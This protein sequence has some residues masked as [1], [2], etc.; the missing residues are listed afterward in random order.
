MAALICDLCGGKLTMGSG[1]IATCDSCGMEHTKDRMK[2]KVQE[3][4]GVV[5]VDE[6]HKVD[7]YLE[8]A[9]NAYDN[10]NQAEA[11]SYCNKIIENDPSNYKAWLIK[12][13]A[14]GWQSTLQSPRFPESVSAFAKAIGN[15]PEEEKGEVAE[16]AKNEIK[17]LA[18]ALIALRA[19]RFIKW[20]DKEEAEGFI[21]DIASILQAAMQFITQA[22]VSVETTELLAPL[23]TQ[24]NQAVVQ[25][26]QKVILPEYKED[27]YPDKRDWE[28]F[29][30]RIGHC[31]ALVEKAVDF[32]N[33]DDDVVSRYENLIFLHNQA[34]DS[35]SWTSEYYD[36]SYSPG[37][38]EGMKKAQIANFKAQGFIP[39]AANS[40]FWGK[41]YS[42]TDTAKASRRTLIA[43]YQS[44]INA[45][46]AAKEAEKERAKKEATEIFWSTH[47][48]EK[49][50]LDSEKKE[51]LEK[52][53]Q[54]KANNTGHEQIKLIDSRIEE[55]DS[56]LNADR[57]ISSGLSK[58]EKDILLS[59]EKIQ[60][61][62]Q[63][64]LAYDAY[65]DKYPILKQK[66]SFVKEK[67]RLSKEIS[68]K[69]GSPPSEGCSSAG[70]VVSPLLL[71]TGILGFV[72][73]ITAMGV[74]FLI[75][76]IIGMIAMIA[77]VPKNIENKRKHLNEIEN[78]QKQLNDC[79]STLREINAVPPYQKNQ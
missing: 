5:R 6:S 24:I 21:N 57:Q 79:E 53:K 54:L 11:E 33:D 34:I 78:L 69:S 46:K 29:I 48:E 58:K 70:W 20:P 32:C 52:K 71:L 62:L 44:K 13:K 8:M 37:F 60:N 10:S 47:S 4:K 45:I 77:C 16:D 40:R 72:A 61:K 56:V 2:E 30:E 55:I 39:D 74:A 68:D 63:E 17:N 18:R 28:K 27:T 51:I 1:G 43:G 22:G 7:N 49:S 65:L 36:F 59:R 66:D 31:T 15:A 41:E 75:A 35:C 19:E 64:T 76:G 67:E 14:A 23:A 9:Q 3:I 42:L 38:E 26:W 12:G 50:Q 73:E 25:A